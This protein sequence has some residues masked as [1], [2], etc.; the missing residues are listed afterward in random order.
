MYVPHRQDTWNSLSLAVRARGA[1][2]D[3]LVGAVREEVRALDRELP[4][5][6]VK[7]LGTVVADSTAGRRVSVILMAGL[8]CAALA[9][10][11]AGGSGWVRQLGWAGA[12]GR[13]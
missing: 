1:G 3:A 11:G 6:D 2:A 7:T 13:G 12:A 10:A 8:A 5:Y 9:P 4:V